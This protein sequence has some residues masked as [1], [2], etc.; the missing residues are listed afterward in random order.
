MRKRGKRNDFFEIRMAPRRETVQQKFL[1][2]KMLLFGSPIKIILLYRG[3]I[4]NGQ[5]KRRQY[6]NKTSD[7]SLSQKNGHHITLHE[8]IKKNKTRV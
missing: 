1:E 5:R 4:W 8:K 6:K 3:E 2:W 7:P